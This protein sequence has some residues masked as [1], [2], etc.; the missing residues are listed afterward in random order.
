M[1]G[2]VV[3]ASTCLSH[4]SSSMNRALQRSASPGGMLTRD[5]GIVSG[6]PHRTRRV[7]R[8]CLSLCIC[9]TDSSGLPKGSVTPSRRHRCSRRLETRGGHLLDRHRLISARDLPHVMSRSGL[10]YVLY[11][12]F[13]TH[14][15]SVHHTHWRQHAGTMTY[16][17]QLPCI[18]LAITVVHGWLDTL[19][20]DETCCLEL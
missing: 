14:I 19:K 13:Q 16:D 18:I 1:I 9:N 4:R 2:I 20:D 12:P 17:T 11:L 7:V 10:W 5:A 15:L 6:R 8:P 3:V